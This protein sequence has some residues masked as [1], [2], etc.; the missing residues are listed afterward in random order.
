MNQYFKGDENADA[1][2]DL[3]MEEIT[4]HVQAAQKRYG[5]FSSTHEALGV[6]YEEWNELRD[7]VRENAIE[8]IRDEA[9]DLAAVFIRLAIQCRTSENLKARSVK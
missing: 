3:A 9:I 5:D 7:A 6:A 4:T 1:E 2:V 8:A